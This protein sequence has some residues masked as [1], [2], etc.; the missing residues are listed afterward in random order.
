MSGLVVASYNVHGGVDGWGRPYDVA[1]VC[2]RLDA[3]V[4]VLQESWHPDGGSGLAEDIGEAIGYAVTSLPL[5]RCRMY[6]PAASV[7]DR[8]SWGPL[9]WGGTRPG[10]GMDLRRREGKPPAGKGRPRPTPERPPHRGSW[11]LAVLT[12]VDRS[13]TELWDLGSLRRDPARRGAIVVVVTVPGHDRA[14][15]VVGTHMGH[16]SHGSPPQ[17]LDLARRVGALRSDVVLTGDMNLWGPPLSAVFH[18]L[19]RVARGRT[20][21]AWRPLV[22]S[23]HVLVS[24]GLARRAVG[25]VVSLAGSDHLPVRVRIDL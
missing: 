12:R 18:R 23:D 3:D 9:P 21:P 1:D 13:L 11:D 4:L 16:L 7:A 14:L 5:C 22:Q 25:E 8:P 17:F 24:R 6:P 15:T 20:W 10:Q 2:R 19:H